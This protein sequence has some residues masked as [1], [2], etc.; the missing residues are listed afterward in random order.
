M[1]RRYGDRPVTPVVLRATD[2]DARVRRL[3]R[4]VGWRVAA[5]AVVL[6]LL[7]A[8][9]LSVGVSLR[10]R[11]ERAEHG[12]GG[13]GMPGMPGGDGHAGA[14]WVIDRSEVLLIIAVVGLVGV[15][16]TGLVGWVAARR[17]VTPIARALRLQ[18]SFVADA[19]HEL[20]TPLTVLDARVQVLQRRLARGEPVDEVIDRLR[21]D[22]GALSEVLDDLLVAA[23]GTEWDGTP[24]VVDEVVDEVAES[25]RPVALDAGVDLVVDRSGVPERGVPGAAVAAVSLRR[26]LVALVDNGIR[27]TPAGGTVTVGVTAGAAVPALAR[28]TPVVE[29]RVADT[30]PGLVVPD[31]AGP[32]GDATVFDRFVHAGDGG[33]RRGFG[34]GLALVR[35]IAEHC[36]GSVSVTSVAGEGATFLLRIPGVR[37][38]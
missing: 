19:S 37:G 11:R 22:T 16:L 28:H 15:P 18:R 4:T 25:M 35:D 30:G 14:H 5:A 12:P 38:G 23:E 20:R 32:D 17:A 26:A 10:S 34:I 1:S 8:A 33:G 31:G 7:G 29:F 24:T 6:V 21:R 9:A 3:A 27:H 2:D 36:G 13:T